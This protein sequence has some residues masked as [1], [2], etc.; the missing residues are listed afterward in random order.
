M[1]ALNTDAD[2]FTSSTPR[3]FD[4]NKDD[5][6]HCGGVRMVSLHAS[7]GFSQSM[8]VR[9]SDEDGHVSKRGRPQRRDVFNWQATNFDVGMC[10]RL[11]R[12]GDGKLYF[13]VSF[14][15]LHRIVLI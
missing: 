14:H 5:T 12:F 7:G 11:M 2:L 3:V 9:L 4:S 13:V 10:E 8:L 6:E 1:T 15:L